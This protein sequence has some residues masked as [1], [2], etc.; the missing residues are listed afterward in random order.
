[1]SHM[2]DEDNDIVPTV[3]D[4]A[5]GK[6]LG[7]MWSK[8]EERHQMYWNIYRPAHPVPQELPVGGPGMPS[9]SPEQKM[10]DAICKALSCC[11]LKAQPPIWLEPSATSIRLDRKTRLCDGPTQLPPG[12]YLSG[13][14][15]YVDVLCIEIPDLCVGTIWGI[16]QLLG[17]SA[18]F[19]VVEWREE[20][21]GQP[22]IDGV[23]CFQKADPTKMHRDIEP[24]PLILPPMSKFCLRARNL[25]LGGPPKEAWARITGQI[26][27]IREITA[28]GSYGEFCTT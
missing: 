17:D 12:S 26:V 13:P 7:D 15:P 25:M 21:N 9:A 8:L 14:G 23:Y 1:M 3:G 6:G 2:F 5:G 11:N 10:A 20:R 16:G 19:E 27:P 18:D 4:L 28:N 22:I 24:V